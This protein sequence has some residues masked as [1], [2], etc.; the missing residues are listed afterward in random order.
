M[1]KAEM[2][3]Y[4]KTEKE[5][6]EEEIATIKERNITVKLS[7][8]DCE[9]L[10]SKCGEYGLSA[11]ELIAYFVGDLVGGTYSNG[12]DERDLAN[13]WLERCL[14]GMFP[15]NTLLS[16]LLDEGYNPEDYLDAMDNIETAKEDKKYIEEH[17]EEADGEEPDWI[18]D[19]IAHW[20]EELKYMRNGW[21]PESEPDMD[22]EIKLIKQWVGEREELLKEEKK[23][24]ESKAEG[25]G[26]QGEAENWKQPDDNVCVHRNGRKR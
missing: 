20:E 21:K 8:A 4:V 9:R 6:Q 3:D 13:R 22:K 12:S 10:M 5:R 16:H 15:E 11:G 1:E 23:S 18:D 24:E 26:Q 25:Q 2:N 17:P 19:D 7:D 14:F